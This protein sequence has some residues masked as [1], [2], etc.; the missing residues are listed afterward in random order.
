M[1]AIYD[2]DG[3]SVTRWTESQIRL[4]TFFIARKAAVK[5]IHTIKFL[6]RLTI[7][8]STHLFMTI[9][10]GFSNCVIKV[11]QVGLETNNFTFVFFRCQHALNFE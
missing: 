4:V 3:I 2:S 11:R 5:K 7:T 8:Y 9:G 1:I 6:K 10:S